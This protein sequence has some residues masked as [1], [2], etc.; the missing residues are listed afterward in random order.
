MNISR[1]KRSWIIGVS[2]GRVICGLV[3]FATGVSAQNAPMQVAGPSN[4]TAVF[5]THDVDA[6]NEALR[7]RVQAAMHADPYF[8]DRHVTVSVENGAVV[9]RGFVFSDW[10]LRDALRIARKAAVD[11]PVVD[12]LSIKLGG[13][14]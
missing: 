12:N 5:S 2:L 10:E 4:S 13:S 11:T 7:K 6:G 9:L 1:S 14:K 3:G 8:Y